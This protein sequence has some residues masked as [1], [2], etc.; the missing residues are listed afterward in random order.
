MWSM[1]HFVLTTLAGTAAAVAVGLSSAWAAGPWTELRRADVGLGSNLSSTCDSEGLRTAFGTGFDP[2]LGYTVT[3]VTVDG[4]DARCGGDHV[5]VVITGADGSP[6]GRGG[7]V[8]IG[9]GAGSV[10]APVPAVA[11]TA[12]S[13][14]HTLLE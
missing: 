12:V 7:P 8:L 5:T 2:A 1:R 11:V 9:A 6:I 14:V 10:T 3:S 4:L 13:R